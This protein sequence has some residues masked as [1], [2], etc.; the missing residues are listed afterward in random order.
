[1]VAVL[2][3]FAIPFNIVRMR[4]PIVF[5][6][7]GIICSPVTILRSDKLGIFSAMILLVSFAACTLAFGF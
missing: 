5:P 3:L 4:F 7:V 6:V 2:L 1:M